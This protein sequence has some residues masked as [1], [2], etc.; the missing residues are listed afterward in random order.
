M[1]D[2]TTIP[3]A[4][5]KDQSQQTLATSDDHMR[6]YLAWCSVF[7]VVLLIIVYLFTRDIGILA[8]TTVVGV[9]VLIVYRYY[10]TRK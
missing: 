2:N 7:F 5:N 9:V 1:N 10:F 8:G 6:R 4:S 3:D